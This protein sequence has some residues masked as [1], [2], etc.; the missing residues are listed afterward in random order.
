AVREG[1]E[2]WVSNGEITGL[3]E[4]SFEGFNDLIQVK[5]REIESLELTIASEIDSKGLKNL[6]GLNRVVVPVSVKTRIGYDKP[7]TEGWIRNLS[8]A[9]PEWISLHG[10]TLK[11]MYEGQA[12]W[13]EIRKG[14]EA[15]DIPMLAN[16]DIKTKEDVDRVLE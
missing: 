3:S 6:I 8:E 5:K 11:Q 9:K 1:V 10:R 4:R 12:D 7:V 2:H 14:V 15:T 13:N 16:G